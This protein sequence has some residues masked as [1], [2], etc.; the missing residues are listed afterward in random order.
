VRVEDGLIRSR[1]LGAELVPPLSLVLDDLGI[2]YDPGRDS[3][4]ERLI[5][6]PLPPGGAERAGR[7]RAAI[8]GAGLTKYNLGGAGA[9]GI[10]RLRAARPG[11][12]VVL[13]PGQV[14]D[15]AAIRLG[16][17]AVRTNRDL[18][19]AARAGEPG[20]ILV[21]KPHP[22]VEAGL[23]PGAVRDADALADLVLVRA[24]PAAVLAA[25]DRV[26]TITSGLG[27]EALMRGVPVVV[28]G[29]PFYAGWGLTDD[30]GPVP[31]RRQPLGAQALDRLV[32][33]ALIA[34]PRYLDPLT[35]APCPP[36]LAVERLAA[37]QTGARP[38]RLR[39]LAKVQ[40]WLAGQA[41]LWR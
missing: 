31:G 23:R 26:W 16:A 18:L 34:Y 36:E 35:G 7:L 2:Y 20:A 12:P 11:A 37:G 28:L 15:D 41:W 14:E 10:A 5:A 4:L 9:E 29:A 21:Y 38:W 3:R 13:V 30:R 32:H 8:V 19:Q 22:D 6:A 1:G 33:A 24:D 39:T 40:G 17:G 27:F 25:V